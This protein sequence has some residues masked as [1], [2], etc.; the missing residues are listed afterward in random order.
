MYIYCNNNPIMYRDP[1]GRNF[2]ENNKNLFTAIFML[3]WIDDLFT[4]A[5]SSIPNWTEDMTTFMAN[6]VAGYFNFAKGK[7]YTVDDVF[8]ELK[9]LIEG[10]VKMIAGISGAVLQPVYMTQNYLNKDFSELIGR[11]LS[12]AAKMEPLRIAK[13]LYFHAAGTF[14]LFDTWIMSKI[15]DAESIK[16]WIN[17]ANPANIG[18]D[19]DDR[20]SAFDWLWRLPKL[21]VPS[22]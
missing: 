11:L 10:S 17:S 8:G 3:W 15:F 6:Q 18:G 16:S 12:T 2:I 5:I 22:I 13:E 19:S 1:S 21:I 7:G 9:G 14:G 20:L 4:N